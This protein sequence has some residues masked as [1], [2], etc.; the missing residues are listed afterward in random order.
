MFFEY[1]TNGVDF[2]NRIR[3]TPGTVNGDLE[4]PVRV[5]LTNL[6][7]RVTY[8][9]RLT[10]ERTDNPTSAGIG[11]VKTLQAD[12]LYG[13]VQKFSREVE[14]TNHSS[15]LTVN[16]VPGGIGGWRFVGESVWRVSGVPV[17]GLT[18]GDRLI[19]YLAEPGY[20]QPPREQVGIVTG[21]EPMVLERSY[22]QTPEAG[23]AALRVILGPDGISAVSV[24]LASRAQWRLKGE[25]VWR[26]SSTE[27]TGLPPGNY[28]VECK[29][30]PG[31][32][33]PPGAST[34]LDNGQSKTVT[35]TY[36]PANAPILN[37]PVVIPFSTSSGSRSFPYAY[38]G[39]FRT[40]AGSQSGFVVKP[41]VVATTS[42]AIFNDSTLTRN[43]GMQWLLQRDSGTYEPN[44]QVPR[45]TYVFTGYE[46]Q[47][48][49]EGTPGA[50]SM[51]SQDLNVAALYFADD[52]GRGGFSGYLASDKQVNEFLQS[53][54]SKT[55]VG[56]PVNGVSEAF[57]GRMHATPLSAASFA[58]ELG[59]I[60]TSGAIRGLGG[61]EGGP[62]CVQFQQG[63]Y[64]PAGIYL[65]GTTRSIVRAIDG[66]VV[67]MFNRAEISANGGDNNTGGGITHSSFTA[68]AA[69][70]A[71]ALKVTIQPAAARDA[72]AGWR[73]HPESSYRLSGAQKTGLAAGKY[74][75]ELKTASGFE[76]PS[77][78]NVTMVG[79]QLTEI[80]FTYEEA[81]IAPTVKN[82]A[83]ISIDQ[84]ASSGGLAVTLFDA[85][86]A[87]N[88]LVL[89]ATSSNTV[90]IPNA[91]IVLG[92]TGANRTVTISPATS[93][94]G[95][96]IISLKVSDGKLTDTETFTVTVNPVN[97]P[98][99]ITS[100]ANQGIP[101]NTS[102]ATLPI[103][104]GDSQTPVASL[105]LTGASSNTSLVPDANIVFGGSGVSR[106]VTVT[107]LAGQLGD[108]TITLTVGDGTL[109]AIRTFILTVT[110]SPVESWRF[111]NFGTANN[112]GNA[113]DGADPDGDGQANRAEYAAGTNPN[114]GSDV[115]RISSA[116]RVGTVF[117]TV[118]PGRAGRTYLLQRRA[119][120]EEGGWD[121]VASTGL[122]VA[123]GFVALVDS[124]AFSS[125]GFY[126]VV[127]EL[128]SP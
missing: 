80:T 68:I 90:L 16:L 110:G 63:A 29:A 122:S 64:F 94:T 34:E 36:P 102:T 114:L 100:V 55:M 77:S 97:D 109:T 113:G 46:A 128:T 75:L 39:Q 48:T 14:A 107:P 115:F 120:L 5:D 28:L 53:S 89:T 32:N 105:T 116:T 84:G 79:G 2:T 78:Q 106:T 1:G 11:E 70:T 58:W 24:P 96:A 121:T 74:T 87:E 49:S 59:R 72:G 111:A 33:T 12:A 26:D 60:Y 19:E 67:D 54:V 91:G 27:V 108:S 112:A 61:M 65:G 73:L 23:S 41:R 95:S 83:N 20:I 21:E 6:E 42:L 3:A 127:I 101:A 88:S 69:T 56:Y 85:D 47:R 66:D 10:A 45:G 50:L 57:H 13:L 30:I 99:T 76:A 98:P 71:A 22:Y 4:I 92:G 118:I 104:V 125:L 40:D 119:D 17:G 82:V 44:P 52:A 7:P 124:N 86:D 117:S 18:T 51:T 15:V 43:T 31:R 38:V 103:A 62:V 81:N 123:D 37:P 9:Y 126:R 25:T 35:V 8:H 93:Q